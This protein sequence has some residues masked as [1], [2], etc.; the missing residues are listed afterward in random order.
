MDPR[1]IGEDF[2]P[3]NTP[4]TIQVTDAGSILVAMM[5]CHPRPG[6]YIKVKLHPE[7][8]DNRTSIPTMGDLAL[9]L[10][11]CISC[12]DGVP[13]NGLLWLA[14]QGRD[15]EDG[16]YIA[17]ISQLFLEQQANLQRFAEEVGPL[18]CEIKVLPPD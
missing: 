12:K 7:V 15:F 5:M 3:G 17:R 8:K 2:V 4:Q 9:F 13:H 1:P 18:I 16:I 10:A 11:N 14:S 6:G